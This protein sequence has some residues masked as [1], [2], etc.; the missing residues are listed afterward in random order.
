MVDFCTDGKGGVKIRHARNKP[1]DATSSY[2]R[3]LLVSTECSRIV[4]APNFPRGSSHGEEE[5][6][7]GKYES[8]EEQR[9]ED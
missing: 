1:S 3:T 9:E 6:E 2:D 4:G 7:E 8:A 5:D